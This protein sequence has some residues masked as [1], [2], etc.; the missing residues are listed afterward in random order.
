MKKKTFP[1]GIHPPYFKELSDKNPIRVLEAPPQVSI[2]LAQHLGTPCEA[3]VSVGEDVRIGT[4]IARSEKLISAPI[5]SPV[6]GKVKAIK[7][8]S[9]PVIGKYNSVVIDSD[10]LDNIEKQPWAHEGDIENITPPTVINIAKEAGMVGLGGAGFPT[11]VKL[12]PPK[13]KPVDTFILN[14]AECEPYITCDARIM[15]EHPH[16]IL[17]GV[18]LIMKTLGV[19]KGYIGIEDNKPEAIEKMRAAL[20][21]LN[22]KTL[23]IVVLHTKYPQGGEKQLIKAITGEEVPPGGLPFDVGCIVDNV[24][25]AYALY[26]AVYKG[27]P[28]YERVLTLT[29]N[30]LKEAVNVR[31]RVGTPISYIVEKCSGFK[32]PPFKVIIGGPMMGI[33]Q[34]DM[35][36]PVIKGTSGILLLTKDSV[37]VSPTGYCIRCGKCSEVCP[38]NLIPTTIARASELSRID[39]AEEF[40]IQ[41]CIECGACGYVCPSSIPLVHLIKHGKRSILCQI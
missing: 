14:G 3:T 30:A 8:S 36:A 6:S 25:T 39:I 18:L 37:N 38:V 13:G 35:N 23:E 31:V 19:N 1:G 4:L 33:S 7:V 17:K 40:Y 32:E 11:H 27:K 5:H 34:Y 28:L 29:G 9:H 41:D 12:N 15:V 22:N 10:S 16:D 26:E 21:E 20:N 24:Q 2:P